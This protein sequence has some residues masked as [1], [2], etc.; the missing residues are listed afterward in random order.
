MATST[1]AP[2]LVKRLFELMVS[3]R[4]SDL[5][6]KPGSKP[7]MRVDGDVQFVADEATSK[8]FAR[9]LLEAVMAGRPLPPP[10]VKEWDL[11]IEFPGIGRFRGNIFRQQ[12]EMG[13]V[14]RHINDSIPSFEEL[15][16][17]ARPLQRLASLKRGLI[18][19]TGVAGSG[20]STTIAAMLEYINQT[21]NSHIVTVED[22]IEY[23][24]TPTQ[25]I[26]NQREIGLDTE[27]FAD[28]MKHVVRQSPDVIL[29]G[30]MRDK[31]TMEAAIQA[32]ET[33]HLV[34]STLHTVNAIQTVERIITFFPP[35][36]HDLLRLQLSM[37]LQ[38]VVSQRL[39]PKRDSK[40]RVPAVELMVSTPTIKEILQEGRTKEIYS[41]IAEGHEYYGSQTFNQSLKTL[42]QSSV[43]SLE[44]AMA[45][46]DNPDEL[47]LEIRGISRGT[48]S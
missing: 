35:H 32:A 27:S 23:M 31:V 19:V 12:G 37:V 5:F 25:S 1:S 30:E 21:R 16:M 36:Q 34:F 18:L 2:P 20:K 6:I 29:V 46:A 43:I 28:A 4:G 39:I 33:G 13:F 3:G 11:A 38:G 44:E 22:P 48:K 10:D 42:Y 8:E 14:F 9:T 15:G 47:K 24:Y 26:I 17:P 45:A 40:G 41:A 7:S